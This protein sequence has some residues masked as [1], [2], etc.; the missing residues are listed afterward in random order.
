MEI[1]TEIQ[2]KFWKNPV[3]NGNFR[4]YTGIPGKLIVLTLSTDNHGKLMKFRVNF[5]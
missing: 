4:L 5:R 2:C 1:S 3:N